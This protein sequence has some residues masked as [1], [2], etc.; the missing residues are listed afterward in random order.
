VVCDAEEQPPPAD[1]D[2]KPVF[3]RRRG[4]WLAW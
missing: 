2:L 4:W 3:L 1:V